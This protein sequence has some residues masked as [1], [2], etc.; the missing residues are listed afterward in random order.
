NNHLWTSWFPDQPWVDTQ[1]RQPSPKPAAYDLVTKRFDPDNGIPL[2][3]MLGSQTWQSPQLATPSL[4]GGGDPSNQPSTTQPTYVNNTWVLCPA[5]SLGGHA[6]WGLALYE[7]RI[8]W[9]DHSYYLFDDDYNVAFY[10][11]DLA[12]VTENRLESREYLHSEFNSDQTINRF[13]TW[14]WDALHQAVDKDGEVGGFKHGPWPNVQPIVDGKEAIVMGLFGLDCAH[15]C[16]SE[17]HP[18]Y[19]MAIHLKDDP[20]DDI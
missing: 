13:H 15:S 7:G 10:R 16:G 11:D 14:Y 19:A 5:G 20:N 18:I 1:T 9:S 4:C 12:G 6:N 2:N 17:L 8:Y 3:P